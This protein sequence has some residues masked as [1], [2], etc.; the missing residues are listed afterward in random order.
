MGY[1]NLLKY[2]EFISSVCRILSRIA[3]F[4]EFLRSLP[5][6]RLHVLEGGGDGI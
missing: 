6:C 5:Y 1:A 4:I 3:T 2:Q